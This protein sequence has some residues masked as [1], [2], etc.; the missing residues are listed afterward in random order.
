MCFL[1]FSYVNP[2][3]SFESIKFKKSVFDIFTWTE[4]C[5][6]QKLNVWGKVCQTE[7]EVENTQNQHPETTIWEKRADGKM[8]KI[9]S[10]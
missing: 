4:A 5:M 9:K 8:K 2:L 7:I 10:Y 3:T 6:P 1:M